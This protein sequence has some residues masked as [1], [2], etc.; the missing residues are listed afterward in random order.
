M[1]DD[2]RRTTDDG[3][4]G[5]DFTVCPHCWHLN[6]LTR[7]CARCLADTTTLLQESG[8]RRWVAPIQSPVPVR[9]GGRLSRRQRAI[10]LGALVLFGIGQLGVAFAPP[11]RWNRA[12]A[13]SVTGP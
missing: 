12:V 6:P 4:S 1:T 2:R 11:W 3:P 5:P 8:G 7:I 13:P 9:V 10:L